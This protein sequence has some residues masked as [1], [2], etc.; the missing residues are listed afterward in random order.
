[1]EMGGE[2]QIVAGLRFR[3]TNERP[4]STTR[5]PAHR[6]GNGRRDI[7]SAMPLNKKSI[8]AVIFDYGNTLIEFGKTQILYCDMALANTLDRH[9][10]K[11][12]YAKFSEIR[13]RNRL[14][15]YSGDPPKYK[16]NDMVEI[17]TNLVRELYGVEPSPEQLADILRTRFAIFVKVVQ[18]SDYTFGLLKKLG[19]KYRLGIL[20]NYPDGNAIRQS[21]AS[22]GLD[23][24]FR[25]VVV[26]G[27]LGLVKPHPVPFLTILDQLGMKAGRAVIVGDN[28]LADIQGGKQAGL[29]TILTTQWESPEN[30]PRRKSDI[31]PDATIAHLAELE[32]LLL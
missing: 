11:P 24:F 30:L 7:I 6:H 22:T 29:Q 13:T 9:F 14:A 28:W 26:S 5:T 19:R 27:D 16:E 32:G 10:G 15:P 23:S 17:S 25:S 4:F 20:S 8:K 1:M 21:L 18:A 31:E 12:D 2:V 3:L